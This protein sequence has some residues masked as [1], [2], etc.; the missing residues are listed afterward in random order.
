MSFISGLGQEAA[1][2]AVGGIM[3]LALGGLQ[4]Q[5]EY[6]QQERYQRLQ[7]EGQKEMAL[8][9]YQQQ[10]KLWEDTGYKAQV[11][12]LKRAGLNP[13]LLY[14]K[15]GAGGSTQ[16]AQGAGPGMGSASKGE[17][18]GMALMMGQQTAQMELL[19]AQKENI[20]ADTA[21]KQAETTNTETN[22]EVEKIIKGIRE[23]E[24]DFM[25]ESYKARLYLIKNEADKALQQLNILK[26]EAIISEN[27][28]S[29]EIDKVQIELLTMQLNN[30]LQQANI[31][32]TEEETK[33]IATKILQGWKELQLTDERNA[34][35]RYKAEVG[36][37]GMIGGMAN[38]A[39]QSLFKIFKKGKGGK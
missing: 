17:G 5:Q 29:I 25:G 9:N 32:K 34:I 19:K 12:Q 4:N 10:M 27:T 21:K 36:E 30:D 39:I 18:L 7:L 1:S 2:S 23:L 26:N 15:G 22:T 13:G 28:W 6:N 20:E 24:Q 33:A 3:G 37:M 31:K 8:F 16:A 11:E 14:G 35:E 38:N